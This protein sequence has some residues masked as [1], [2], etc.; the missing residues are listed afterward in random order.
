VFARSDDHVT[1]IA[2]YFAGKV[3]PSLWPEKVAGVLSDV[4]PI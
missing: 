1:M 2:A 3:W 4:N